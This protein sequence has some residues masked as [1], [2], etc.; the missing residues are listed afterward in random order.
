[1]FFLRYV[2]SRTIVP[3][4]VKITTEQLQSNEEE[5]CD[6]L[7]MSKREKTVLLWT[8]NATACACDY[9]TKPTRNLVCLEGKSTRQC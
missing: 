8:D 1:M 6:L 5:C 2:L 4:V 7:N 9:P 3:A